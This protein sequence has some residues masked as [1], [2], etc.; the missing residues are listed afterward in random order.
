M[1]KEVQRVVLGR[2][3]LALLARGSLQGHFD[4]A[5]GDGPTVMTL[6]RAGLLEGFGTGKVATNAPIDAFYRAISP[7]AEYLKPGASAELK[8][9]RINGIE[10]DFILQGPP[11]LEAHRLIATPLGT[12][13]D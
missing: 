7:L 13:R 10:Y 11:A 6:L 12:R 9:I 2:T 8:G 3:E 1:Q 5:S 4:I